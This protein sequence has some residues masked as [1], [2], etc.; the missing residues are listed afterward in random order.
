[1]RFFCVKFKR[2][3]L[4]RALNN[5]SISQ[6]VNGKCEILVKLFFLGH[7]HAYKFSDWQYFPCVQY[8]PWRQSLDQRKD[9]LRE[10]EGLMKEWRTEKLLFGT[11]NRPCYSPPACHK[12]WRLQYRLKWLNTFTSKTYLMKESFHAHMY[13][14]IHVN[15]WTFQHDISMF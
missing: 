11:R 4:K 7:I 6:N 10:D 15:T 8:R 2:C 3:A 9:L 12:A 13:L 1:M 14:F 5:L